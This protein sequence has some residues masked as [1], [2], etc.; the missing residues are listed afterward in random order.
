MRFIETQSITKT[1]R[2]LLA[3]AKLVDLPIA[4]KDGSK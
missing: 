2:L 4:S 3:G 1:N